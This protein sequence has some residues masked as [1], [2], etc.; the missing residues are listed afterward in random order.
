MITFFLNTILHSLSHYFFNFC[1]KDNSINNWREKF[2]IKIRYSYLK[3]HILFI[4]LKLKN[5]AR[6]IFMT[7]LFCKVEQN[8]RSMHSTRRNHADSEE[9]Y[10]VMVWFTMG[11]LISW[12]TFSNNNSE[13]FLRVVIFFNYM[14][15]RHV[16]SI[17]YCFSGKKIFILFLAFN[18]R[19]VFLETIFIHG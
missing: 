16:L 18:L 9:Y 13:I 4:F 15:I 11:F 2:H 14:Y 3:S 7:T 6:Y 17:F 8:S 19:C 1:I 10:L 12:P 5:L